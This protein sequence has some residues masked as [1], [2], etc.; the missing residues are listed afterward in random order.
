VTDPEPE[1]VAPDS[2]QPARR[3][4]FSLLLTVAC[5]IIVAVYIG[6]PLGSLMD[7]RASPLAQL[8]RPEDSLRRLVTR[9]LDLYEAMRHGLDWEWRVYR[10]FS[11]GEDPVE[12][13]RSWYDEMVDTVDSPSAELGRAILLGEAGDV[14]QTEE[15]ISHWKSWGESGERM[16][17]WIGA[18]YLGGPPGADAGRAMIA[19]I[20]DTLKTDWFADTL[21]AR[22]ATRIED[23]PA[24]TEAHAAI[25]SRGRILQLRLRLL[26]ALTVGLIVLG[27]LTLVLWLARRP[28]AR[29]ADAPLPPDWSLAD[30]Y[31]LFVRGLGVP[32][33]IILMILFFLRRET[34][35]EPV[36]M[37]LAELP[38]LWWV[39][40]DLRARQTSMGAAFGLTPSRQ[41]WPWLAG[42]TLALVGLGLL[43]DAVIDGAGSL[44]G[45]TSHWTDGFPENILWD[46]RWLL[47]ADTFD[48]SVWAP[49]VEELTFR[50]LL[51]G[52][53]R[54]RLGP[55]PSAILSAVL[56]TL[57]HG[58]ATAG[59][60]SVLMSGLLWAW[61]YERTRS[62]LPGLLAH[63]A[64][65]LMSTL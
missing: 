53:L 58:Y 49:M 46:R 32:Q 26:M 24:R 59:S 57:P 52:T 33:A 50:G 27:A 34:P 54:T 2:A 35:F 13:A 39:V 62:L 44:V 43:G 28:P 23:A 61:A 47:V 4:R 7:S 15:A 18:A 51:Y 16:A 1:G 9:E 19:L 10:I 17:S 11:G 25:V 14:D 64:N 42:V 65:N 60:L 38:L 36:L 48:A 30:G 8:D 3:R 21:A 56:F 40:V 29:V 12:Q 6:L 5:S 37:M 55:W 41:A 22:I 31:A 20:R 63:S 45:F